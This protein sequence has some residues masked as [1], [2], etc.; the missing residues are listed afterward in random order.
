M[1]QLRNHFCSMCRKT[2]YSV[3]DHLVLLLIAYSCL[4]AASGR[5]DAQP[6]Q[7]PEGSQRADHQTSTTNM[8]INTTGSESNISAAWHDFERS[9]L[10]KRLSD[11]EK[12]KNR[13]K[14]GNSNDGL[15]TLSSSSEE[16]TADDE[17]I[18]VVTRC[19]L[20][21]ETIM[22]YGLLITFALGTIGNILCFI[23][24]HGK[25]YRGSS[26]SVILSCMIVTDEIT[27]LFAFLSFC[28]RLHMDVA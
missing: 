11:E 1:R 16:D 25:R 22:S 2:I 21:S 13:E 28:S 5:N 20:T 26:T 7:R 17:E 10:T 19:W 15:T 18:I 6:S 23:P 27:L 3:A 14:R 4:T 9:M 24:L 12:N 8:S